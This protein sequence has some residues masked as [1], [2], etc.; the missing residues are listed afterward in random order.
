MRSVFVSS[1][2][3]LGFLNGRRILNN[4]ENCKFGGTEV[5]IGA[6]DAPPPLNSHMGMVSRASVFV[7]FLQIW[8]S[9]SFS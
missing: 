7:G 5:L 1:A 9:I 3:T 4:Q 8:V 6:N 2:G